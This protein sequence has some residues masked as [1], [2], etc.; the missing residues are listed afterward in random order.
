ME[1]TRSLS[2]LRLLHSARCRHSTKSVCSIAKV[3]TAAGLDFA[4]PAREWPLSPPHS[5]DTPVCSGAEASQGGATRSDLARPHPRTARECRTRGHTKHT[6]HSQLPRTQRAARAAAP[7]G[8]T[9][10]RATTGDRHFRARVAQQAHRRATALAD[11][12]AQQGAAA[13]DTHPRLRVF[14][15]HPPPL[16]HAFLLLLLF[17]YYFIFL[18]FYLSQD[19]VLWRDMPCSA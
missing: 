10:G 13:R 7:P 17:Y 1:C 16:H 11:Q 14:V 12:A 15:T 3:V 2:S 6:A 5:T 8:P 19:S 9:A 4:P 18:F